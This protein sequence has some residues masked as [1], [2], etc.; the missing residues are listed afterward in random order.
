MD[1]DQSRDST[2][3]EVN[4]KDKVN[5]DVID[6][7]VKDDQVEKEMNGRSVNDDCSGVKG[8]DRNDDDVYDELGD[9]KINEDVNKLHKNNV[10]QSN[11]KSYADV[12]GE[13]VIDFERKL[14][15][16]PTEID[17]NGVEVVVFDEV[18]VEEGSKRWEKT[19]CAYFVGYGM[20]VNE[21]RYNLR[22]MWSRYG[23]KDIMDSNNGVFFIKFNTDDGIEFVVNKGPWLV[24]NKPLIVQRWDINMCLDK[25]KPE[26]IPLW[27][28][29]CNVPLEAWTTKG[30]SALASRVGKPIMMDT[31]TDSMCKMGV[32]RIG[33]ARVLVEVSAKKV[34]P[35]DIEVV[36]KNEA[37]EIICGKI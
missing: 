12:T 2:K 31:T 36:Y 6:Q 37:K 9:N 29:L 26:I 33:F 15:V 1:V 3:T 16:V 17:D 4:G 21:L 23:F 5:E 28:K 30:I 34:L 7:S 22:K 35:Y 32:G 10:N 14:V 18:M 8:S 24:K 25:T 27:I 20:S 11:N 13:N 19:V